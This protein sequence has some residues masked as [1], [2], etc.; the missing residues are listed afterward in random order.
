MIS[1]ILKIPLLISF[2]VFIQNDRDR[3]L[4]LED[5]PTIGGKFRRDNQR[6][7]GSRFLIVCC[8][9]VQPKTDLGAL[10]KTFGNRTRLVQFRIRWSSNSKSFAWQ[11]GC[12]LNMRSVWCGAT[13]LDTIGPNWLSCDGPTFTSTISLT[14]VM[15]PMNA[16]NDISRVPI[17]RSFTSETRSSRKPKNTST[18]GITP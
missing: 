18:K 1:K 8:P 4:F 16:M 11:G 17:P 3:R 7:F 10:W 14:R 2:S 12:V 5:I 6:L 9:S 13:P 15:K